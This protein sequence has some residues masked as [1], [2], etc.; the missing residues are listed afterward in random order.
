MP[1]GVCLSSG[2][3]GQLLSS[4]PDLTQQLLAGT[5]TCSPF[6]IDRRSV[7]VT[8]TDEAILPDPKALCTQYVVLALI[9]KDLLP[10]TSTHTHRPP[11][12]APE[13]PRVGVAPYL[14]RGQS[15]SFGSG[16]E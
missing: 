6:V 13:G 16:M 10:S 8:G 4:S 14:Q 3:R 9:P 7:S 2:C 1:E 11:G 12:G 5:L 15:V